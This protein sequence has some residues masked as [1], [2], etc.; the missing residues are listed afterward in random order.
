MQSVAV[1]YLGSHFLSLL[2]NGIAAVALPLIVLQ[3]TGSP[4]SVGAVAT[5]TALPALLV[6]L[7][8]GRDTVGVPRGPDCGH[9]TRT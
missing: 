5:A 6:G 1:A 2:G 7:C 8:A 4:L 3:S 9:E